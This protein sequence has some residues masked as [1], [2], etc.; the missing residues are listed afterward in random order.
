MDFII[1]SFPAK[2]EVYQLEFILYGDFVRRKNPNYVAIRFVRDLK[3]S[4]AIF[5]KCYD[6]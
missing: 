1:W 5:D 6:A 3:R 2:K 4:Q